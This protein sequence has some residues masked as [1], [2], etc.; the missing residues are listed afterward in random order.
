MATIRIHRGKWQAIVR[1]KGYPQQSK[2]FM[3][4]AHALKWARQLESNL[5]AGLVPTDTKILDDTTVGDLLVKYRDSVS[6]NKKG[7]SSEC[8]RLDSF[9]RQPWAKLTLAKVSPGVFSAYRD[10][11][12]DIVKPATVRRD[13]GLLRAV[14]E[15]AIAEWDFPLNGNPLVNIKKPREPEARNRRLEPGE[16]ELLLKASERHSAQWLKFGIILAIE[17]GLRRGELL[18]LFW[19]DIA[20]DHSTILVRDTKNGYSRTIPLSKVAVDTLTLMRSE[21]A[22]QF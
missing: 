14:F 8:T 12:L 15:T 22:R 4:K 1:R 10:Q 3:T 9:L 20:L 5:D 16:R 18:R 19:G 21:V 7:Y 13:L 17:T 6:I 2:S 11:R